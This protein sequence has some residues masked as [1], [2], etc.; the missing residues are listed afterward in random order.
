MEVKLNRL[1]G[2]PRHPS[3]VGPK[4]EE[5]PAVW[6]VDVYD[7]DLLGEPLCIETGKL[8]V[9]MIGRQMGANFCENS[10]FGMFSVIQRQL[11]V[12]EVKRLHGTAS[13]EDPVELLPLATGPDEEYE[14]Y[15]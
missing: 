14:E 6:R 13:G 8:H 15:E 3:P 9:G 7:D 2:A 5:V 12:E 10:N 11:I 1:F 4:E